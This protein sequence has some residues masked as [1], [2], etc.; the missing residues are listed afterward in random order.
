MADY[1]ESEPNSRG[2][3]RLPSKGGDD[4]ESSGQAILKLLH[5]AADTAEANRRRG[6][7]TAQQL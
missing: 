5:K 4:L 1:S 2:Q 7:E 6:L 3:Y